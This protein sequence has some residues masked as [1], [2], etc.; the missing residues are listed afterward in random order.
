MTGRGCDIEGCEGKHFGR[1]WCRKHYLRWRR[2]G[3]PLTVLKRGPANPRVGC[4]VTG[5]DGKH[6]TRGWCAMHY[7]RWK[8]NGTTDLLT[9]EEIAARR[10]VKLCAVEGCGRRRGGGGLG[11]CQMH[12]WRLTTKGDVGPPGK[13]T[14]VMAETCSHPDGCPRRPIG[15]K[16]W[17]RMHYHRIRKDGDPGPA[18]PLLVRPPRQSLFCTAAPLDGSAGVCGLPT[19]GKGLCSTHAKREQ[20]RLKR[21][22]DGKSPPRPGDPT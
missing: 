6:S 21:V 12:Y 17:C 2:H 19:V 3:N 5:C 13:I 11:Y 22:R 7:E 1:G 16:G 18:G 15:G 14:P 20:R 8:R 9:V 10:P 4:T